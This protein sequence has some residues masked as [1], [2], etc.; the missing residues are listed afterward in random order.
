MLLLL[1]SMSSM[2]FEIH[3]SSEPYIF[4]MS[5]VFSLCKEFLYWAV[6][7]NPKN[8]VGVHHITKTSYLVQNS[9]KAEKIQ[10][11]FNSGPV[12][13]TICRTMIFVS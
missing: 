6:G 5:G 13:S 3:I 2:D 12:K 9:E 11:S 1:L 4:F 7:P 8:A 10:M